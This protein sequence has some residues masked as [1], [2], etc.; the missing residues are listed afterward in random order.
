MRKRLVRLLV[1][2]L[3]GAAIAWLVGRGVRSPPRSRPPALSAAAPPSTSTTRARPPGS[4][5]R[6]LAQGPASVAG[7][8]EASDGSAAASAR[9]SLS[10]LDPSTST[11]SLATG[12]SGAFVFQAVAS[13]T[14]ELR[15]TLGGL[16]APPLRGVLV[17]PGTA[18]TGLVLRLAP[19][20]TLVGTVR[21]ATT[22]L[23]LEACDVRSPTGEVACDHDG[24]FTLG[25]VAPGE[26]PL[27]VTAPGHV[28]R[29]VIAEL[30]AGGRSFV[31]VALDAAARVRGVVRGPE[32]RPFAGAVVEATA[33]RIGSET[34]PER[35]TLSDANGRFLLGGVARG[36]VAI[37]A[38]APGYAQARREIDVGEG[39]EAEV[40]LELSTGGAIA[41][42]VWDG[43]GGA[44]EGAR[45]EAVRLTD[46]HTSARDTSA[47]DGSFRLDGLGPGAYT[48]TAEVNGL[49]ALA[50]G[51]RVRDR[52]ETEVR[53]VLGS[54]VVTGHVRD[55]AGRPVAR[56]L[57][58]AV[59]S[60]AAQGKGE[61][62]STA[63]DGSFRFDGLAGAPYRIEAKQGDSAAEKR[64]VRPS[65]EVELVLPATGTLEGTIVDASGRAV[66]DVSL[67]VFP[68]DQTAGVEGRARR[69]T[70][71]A[72]GGRFKVGLPAGRYFVRAASREAPD[73][74]RE[75]EVRAGRTT[76]VTLTLQRAVTVTGVVV[77]AKGPVAGCR[78][79]AHGAASQLIATADDPGLR[80]TTSDEAGA[81]TLDALPAGVIELRASCEDGTRGGAWTRAQADSNAVTLRVRPSPDDGVDFGGIGATL[82][83]TRDGQV[84]VGTLVP[85]GPAF[86][87]G[88]APGDA[89]AAVDGASTRGQS[90]QAVVNRI[91]GPLATPVSLDLVRGGTQAF[92]T[93]LE[94]E[95]IVLP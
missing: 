34:Q 36:R 60:Y 88:L 2:I 80:E 53:L 44:V 5:R 82:A 69:M 73:G 27:S 8:V 90:L 3:A 74:S 26:L 89:I 62:T 37:S 7:V 61:A 22:G 49:R 78:V 29:Q 64:G 46:R 48:V 15:A 16:A 25:P 24:R 77:G 59:S 28:A 50:P 52:D 75:V 63:P 94:R 11:R 65:D 87:A 35:T 54:D 56:A 32:Q 23:T 83:Q 81:F 10:A 39:Q 33:V 17:R 85:D 38:S 18:L 95:R 76:E 41:G 91:R 84:L 71:L 45:V 72:P 4:V 43:H 21:D 6:S 19:G 58:R 79:S 68:T 31:D 55:E 9:V 47:S 13:G 20:A 1:L 86:E 70:L 40:E 66:E 93:T 57:V 12:A 42:S 92:S 30:A 14:Y 67:L 51:V